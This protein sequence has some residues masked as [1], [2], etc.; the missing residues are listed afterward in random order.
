[1]VYINIL[2]DGI[3]LQND[4][5]VYN[6]AIFNNVILNDNIIHK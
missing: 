3:I 5:S 2:M 1:M 4:V 6:G